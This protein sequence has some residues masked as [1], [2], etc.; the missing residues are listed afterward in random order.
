MLLACV[1]WMVLTM[2]GL[3]MLLACVTW[4]VL[5]LLG[6]LHRY[7]EPLVELHASK[8]VT[9]LRS[10]AAMQCPEVEVEV[11]RSP[12][13]KPIEEAV[14][15]IQCPEVEVEINRSRHCKPIEEVAAIQ[16]PEV[17]VEINR[18]P[19][20]KPIEEVAAIHWLGKE[21]YI[22]DLINSQ[23]SEMNMIIKR[24]QE[25]MFEPKYEPRKSKSLPII[26]E[27]SEDER[28]RIE[29]MV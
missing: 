4:I 21:H 15:A 3:L 26:N 28:V 8:Q 1:T 5:I 11:N 9:T 25:E 14:A 12:H 23:S 29:K 2:L 24:E 10:V 17:E 19:H 16:C 7:L 27:E 22:R 6:T 13:C 20:C 18:S